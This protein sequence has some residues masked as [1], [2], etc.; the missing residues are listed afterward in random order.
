MNWQDKRV[1]LTGGRGFLGKHLAAALAARGA[2]VVAVGRA[3]A[4][5]CDRL[6]T[7]ALMAQVQPQV[8]VHAAVQGGG[9]GW[10]RHHPVESGRDNVLMNVHV[11]DEA[12]R[13]GAELFIGV[14]SACAYPRLCPVPFAED[15]LWDGY[16]E[17]TNG[18]YAQSKRIMMD[19]GRAYWT[20]HGFASVFPILAN[21]YGPHDHLRQERAH[22]VA[23]L[24]LR[25]LGGPDTLS[26][27][28]SGAATR[29]FLFAPDAA[30]GILACARWAEGQPV[31]I[32][33][34][35]EV[36]I[37]RLAQA[38]AQACGF[39]GPVVFDPSKP[40]GQPRKCLSPEL[41][42]EM[43]GWRAPTSLEDG[44]AQTVAWYRRALAAA[45]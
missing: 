44:L 24:I 33:S 43:L 28:G 42:A 19:L 23:G 9:I 35:E 25:T 17:P 3:E 29:E 4:D 12:W 26:V 14:S 32:G 15:T 2:Q 34:G 36:P 11:L 18:P 8:V 21:L 40:D 7:R 13:A 16:P 39:S 31:N 41:A 38:V 30:D 1:L 27:W 6:A 5:L 20:Q 10:M 45:P 37:R 22:V